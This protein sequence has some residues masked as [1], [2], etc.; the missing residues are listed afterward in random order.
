MKTIEKLNV[1]LIV[2]KK[3]YFL[4]I[5]TKESLM[6]VLRNRL[7]LTGTKNG[8]NSGHC[9]TCTVI[10]NNKAVKSCLIRG[11]KM[12]KAEITTIE[13]LSDN[14]QLHPIQEAF[15]QK[16]AVQC[17]FC[18]PGYIMELVA[19]YQTKPYA[20]LKDIKMVLEDHLCRCTGYKPVIEAA[21]LA[22]NLLNK[23]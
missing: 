15:I 6:D 4:T 12:H 8:C 14:Y 9:G 16:F 5:D 17:G 7:N 3:V 18:T 20:T 23:I 11:E 10:M 19:L 21:E 2:N 13:G 22:K 1:E